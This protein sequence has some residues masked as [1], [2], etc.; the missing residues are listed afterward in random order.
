MAGEDLDEGRRITDLIQSAAIAR[1]Y[2]I[3]G[4]SKID[5]AVEFGLSRFQVARMLSKARESGLVRIEIALPAGIDSEL[6]EALR[7]AYGLKHAI[8]VTAVDQSRAA[9]RHHLAVAAAHFLT[10]VVVAGDVLGFGCSRTLNAVTLA[11]THLAR[12]EVIQLTGALHGVDIEQNS[13]ELVRRVAS[14]ADGQAY[15]IYA[16]LVVSDPTTADVL[17]H[18]PQV[19][20]VMNRYQEITKAVIA[21]GSW[22]PPGSLMRAAITEAEANALRDRG[23][24]AEAC[25][26]LLDSKGRPIATNLAERVIAITVEQLRQIPEVI[27]VAGGATKAEAIR[28]VLIGGLATSLV[29]DAGVA[30]ALL[31]SPPQVD[32]DAHL[33]PGAG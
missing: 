16:P 12:C 3:D 22:D 14:I 8:V 25:G 15:P 21:V 7:G 23:V 28:A 2:Y 13:V 10:E 27:A 1:R 30:R 29:T 11:L 6:S 17:R 19:A 9:V 26:R 31:R 32:A 18:Q 24:R 5:I 4:A 33:P 20:E